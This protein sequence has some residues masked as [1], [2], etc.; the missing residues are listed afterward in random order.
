MKTTEKKKWQETPNEITDLEKLFT[1]KYLKRYTG[2]HKYFNLD[3][4][5]PKN[6]KRNCC[7]YCDL[8]L[9]FKLK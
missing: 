4:K 2:V 7:D 1:S 9:C 3:S 5:Y 6:Y 8:L